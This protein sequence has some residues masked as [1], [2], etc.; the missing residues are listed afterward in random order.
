MAVKVV[1][2]VE[3][4]KAVLPVILTVGGVLSKVTSVEAVAVHPLV[5]VTVTI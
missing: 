3:Q 2:V 1:L 5:P 4:F